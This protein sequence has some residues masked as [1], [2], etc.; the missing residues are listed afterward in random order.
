MTITPGTSPASFAREVVIAALRFS[1]LPEPPD[2]EFYKLRYACFVSIKKKGELRGCIGT[3]EPAEPNLGQ[4]IIKNAQSAAFGD[5]RFN[6]VIEEELDDL[7]FSV[8]VLSVPEPVQT[9]D[10]LDCKLYGVIVSCDYRRG[11]LLP[12]LEGV[13][14]I[15]DQIGIAC[16]KAG[17]NPED[18]FALQ[19]FKVTRFDESWKPASG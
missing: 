18:E 19:R 3:L 9:P 4:E 12:D 11:V 14:S 6:A 8:D 7:Q 10:Q 2:D 5:P 1:H 17:I 15:H 13:D 16:Q